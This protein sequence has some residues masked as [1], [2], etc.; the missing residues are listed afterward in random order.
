MD[1]I[2]LSNLISFSQDEWACKQLYELNVFDRLIDF[3]KGLNFQDQALVIELALLLLSNLTQG[4][5]GVLLFLHANDK[6]KLHCGVHYLFLMSRLLDSKSDSVFKFAGNVLANISAIQEAREILLNPEFK[7]IE[8]LTSICFHELKE[9]RLGAEKALRNLTFEYENPNFFSQICEEKLEFVDSLAAL[10]VKI[11]H[12]STLE[13]NLKDT[14][15]KNEGLLKVRGE[16]PLKNVVLREEIQELVDIF[17]VLTNINEIE[18][19]L[20][21]NKDALS[22]LF[23][24]LRGIVPNEI[25]DK[26]DVILCLFCQINSGNI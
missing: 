14:F 16:K 19:K 6:E 3:V 23:L 15:K 7:A 1:T 17:L 18:M 9:I 24:S 10:A 12:F 2:C 20:K 11:V 5:D 21:F 25:K 13:E 26:I 22:D 4:K 8:G